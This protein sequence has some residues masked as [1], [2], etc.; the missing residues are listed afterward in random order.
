MLN[1]KNRTFCPFW[2]NCDR[3]DKCVNALK[4]G[5]RDA[6]QM[7]GQALSEYTE[8]PECYNG[9]ATPISHAP[10]TETISVV[11]I[12]AIAVGAVLPAPVKEWDT[13]A[14]DCRNCAKLADC[15]N[16]DDDS[17]EDLQALDA[18]Q[19]DWDAT[20]ETCFE[21]FYKD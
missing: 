20:G 6:A 13:D 18:D 7:A 10:G 15:D 12:V 11:E 14:E 16:L 19:G 21:P 8:A 3:G 1:Y 9:V 4:P 2:E 17:R 5:T